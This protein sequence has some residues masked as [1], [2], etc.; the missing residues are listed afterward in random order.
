M[1][2]LVKINQLNFH[3]TLTE[4]LKHEVHSFNCNQYMVYTILILTKL[5]S[6]KIPIIFIQYM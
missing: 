4:V 6:R 5:T 2:Y 1:D 3:A